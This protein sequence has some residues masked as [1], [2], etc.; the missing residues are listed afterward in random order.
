MY[1]FI[2]D[3]YGYVWFTRIDYEMP[4]G[5]SWYPTLGH[6][7]DGRVLVTGGFSKCCGGDVENPAL[8]IFDPELWKKGTYNA[9]NHWNLGE[10]RWID[11][12]PLHE[13][14]NDTAPGMKDYTRLWVLTEPVIFQG[15]QYDVGMMGNYVLWRH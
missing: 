11:L 6:L 3:V 15:I 14:R 10:N 7:P 5:L 13:T 12:V 2:C 1:Q 8:N 4:L 9:R